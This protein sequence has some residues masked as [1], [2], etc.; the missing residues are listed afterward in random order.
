[1]N[2]KFVE[3]VF[4]A[5]FTCVLVGVC[6]D[7]PNTNSLE[8]KTQTVDFYIMREQ[9]KGKKNDKMFTFI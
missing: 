2:D 8:M 6:L 4:C 1:M 7:V 9:S 3:A 5:D